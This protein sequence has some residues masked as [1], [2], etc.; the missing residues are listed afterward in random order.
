MQYLFSSQSSPLPS[1]IALQTRGG[2]LALGLALFAFTSFATA[3]EEAVAPARAGT[4]EPTPI[5]PSPVE[6]AKEVASDAEAKHENGDKSDKAEKPGKGDRADKADKHDKADKPNKGDRADKSE[7]APRKVKNTSH[8]QVIAKDL[9]FNEARTQKLTRIADRYFEA[10]HKRL[11]VTGGTRTPEKQAQLMVAKF[12]HGDAV[13]RLYENRVAFKE[14]KKAYESTR[15]TSRAKLVKAVRE[16]I[17]AQV[18]RGEFISK[19]LQFAAA[20]IRSHGMTPD[21]EA[22]FRAAVAAESGV[23]LLDERDGPEAHFHLSF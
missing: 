17:L 8:L 3:A 22:A 10:T 19:H 5:E 23:S 1:R 16:V 15:T 14:I 18:A 4:S 2:A 21:R 20:D 12:L 6:A 13:E 7:D 9:K 11:V